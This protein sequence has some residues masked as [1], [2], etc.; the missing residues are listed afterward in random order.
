MYLEP[1]RVF[2]SKEAVLPWIICKTTF[3]SPTQFE[4]VINISEL[5][6]NSMTKLSFKPFLHIFTSDTFDICPCINASPQGSRKIKL[7]CLLQPS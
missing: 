2:G 7:T 4:N 1:N 5:I 6:M 3:R